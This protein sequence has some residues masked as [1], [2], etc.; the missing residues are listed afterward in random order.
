M[1]N[2]VM[3]IYEMVLIINPSSSHQHGGRQS[4]SGGEGQ[5]GDQSYSISNRT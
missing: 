3:A 1:D 2:L 5:A 4:S